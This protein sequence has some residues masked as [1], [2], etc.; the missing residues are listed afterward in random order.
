MSVPPTS[1]RAYQ[2]LKNSI[3]SGKL[4]SG[5]LDIGSFAD[6]MRMSTTPV[7]EALARLAAKRLVKPYPHQGYMAEVPSPDRLAHLYELSGRL[8]PLSLERAS[9]L[10]RSAEQAPI[11]TSAG[12]YADNMTRLL[13]DMASAQVTCRFDNAA[14]FDFLQC[15]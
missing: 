5:P 10:R 12:S 7:R 3:L 11:F 2:R 9:R 4:S 1:E 6:R 8:I 15:S 14:S 13:Y